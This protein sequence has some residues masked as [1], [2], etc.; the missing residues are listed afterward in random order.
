MKQVF[1]TDWKSSKNRR[2]QRKYIAN[3]PLHTKAKFMA[4]H[5]SKTLI[6]KYNTR[7]LRIR[8]GDKVKILRGQYKGKTGKIDKVNIKKGSITLDSIFTT[9][10][11]GSKSFYPI[12]PSN[13]MVQEI[14][15]DDRK[16]KEKLQKKVTKK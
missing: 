11:D 12:N 6:Q 3:A 9:K 2:K 16:G 13:V 10:R 7:K 15:L 4:S 5:L 14:N 8:S 1:S